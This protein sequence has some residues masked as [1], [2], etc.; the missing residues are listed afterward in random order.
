MILVLE[1]NWWAV[2]LRGLVAVLFGLA[3]WIWPDVTLRVLVVLFGAY[4]L[5]DGI[6]ALVMALRT[7][8]R[9]TRWTALLIEG[10]LGI[11]AGVVTLIWP[12]ITALVLLV[13][14]AAW[15]IITGALEIAAA[16]RLRREIRDE[17]LLGL[18]GAAS[19]LF[20]TILIVRPDVGAVAVTWLIGL[21]AILF[22]VLLL[23]LAFRLRTW[24]RQSTMRGRGGMPRP[25]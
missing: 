23:A 19:V 15:A 14:I 12:N 11:A 13:I 2:A 16:I 17:W 20:G 10:I 8:E 6:F 7:S 4:V 25:A 3:A 21:Y 24:Q 1:R 5:V 9:S 18:S 22:G